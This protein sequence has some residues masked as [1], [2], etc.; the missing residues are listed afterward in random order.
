MV[1]LEKLTVSQLAMKFRTFY[2][3][4]RFIITFTRDGHLFLSLARSIQSMPTFHFLKNH[5][6]IVLPSTPWSSMWYGS[7]RFP[8]QIYTHQ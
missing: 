1:L 5:F 6:N 4:G 3:P 7:L 8:H 2:G